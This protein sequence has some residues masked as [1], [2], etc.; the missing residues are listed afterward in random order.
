V[1]TSTDIVTQYLDAFVDDDPAK[2]TGFVA[3]EFRN[4]HLSALGSGSQGREEYARRLPGFLSTFTDRRYAIEATVEQGRASET[5]IVVRYRFEATYDGHRINIPG[6]MWF[7]VDRG[8]ITS[9]V[10]VWDSLTFLQQ[11]GQR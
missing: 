1:S 9:R 10:D 2:I 7:G 5:D 6:V 11:T 4:E 8:L 3:A